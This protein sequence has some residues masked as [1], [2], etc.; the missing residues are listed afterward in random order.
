MKKYTFDFYNAANLKAYNLN[1]TMRYQLAIL[2]KM[3]P[4][5]KKHSESVANLVCRICEY[6]GFNWQ[7]TIH[8]TM[9]AYLHDVG[10]LAIPQEIL[11][12]PGKLTD[13]EYKIIKT[14]TTKGYEICMK[15]IKLR[16]Y[17]QAAL[18]HHEALNGTGYPN[19]VTKKDIPYIAQIVRVADEYD[20]I[21]SK[22][23]YK[24]HVNISETLKILIKEARPEEHI[25]L[26]AL[27]HLNTDKK[28]GKIN[29][30]ILK[31][32]F[33]VVIDDIIYEMACIEDYITYLK[34]E[35]KRLETINKYYEKMKSTM[36]DNDREYFLEGIH[37]MLSQ[38]EN[39]E[40]FQN[41]LLEYRDALVAKQETI[42]KLDKEIK[43]IKKLKV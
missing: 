11:N 13:E 18:Y 9:N 10:K 2:D 23:Q 6:L 8:S 40:N 25:K 14:H 17:A 33:K 41:V 1:D 12:K 28:L 7:V 38:G 26:I 29:A 39:I 24:T 35:I 16:P 4:I 22:R 31:I 20:A 15:D 21:T 27:D 43:I 32:L 19:G 34:S 3:D 30:R 5:T 37:L 36:K 42:D